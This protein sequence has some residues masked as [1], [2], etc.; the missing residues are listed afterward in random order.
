MTRPSLLVPA[1]AVA[2]LLTAAPVA[3]ASRSASIEFDLA[4][5][6]GLDAHVE[7][8]AGE[9]T[10]EIDNRHSAATYQVDGESTEA[11]LKAQLGKLGLI[12]VTFEPTKTLE[13]N[14]PPKG[15]KGEP[16]TEREGFYLGTIRFNGERE[17]VRIEAT[18]ARGTMFVS[19]N[20]QCRDGKGPIR[21]ESAPRS[22]TSRLRRQPDPAEASLLARDRRCRCFF[23][24]FAIPNRDGRV[25]S[26]FYGAKAENREGMKIGRVTFAKA[27]PS[28]FEFDHQAGVAKVEP[29]QPF[30]GTA[31]YK[32]RKGRDLW[33]SSLRVPLLGADPVSLRGREFR[34]RLTRRL[35]G[36]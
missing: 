18:R 26:L 28:A 2:L 36:D 6:N 30:T 16:W 14:K 32:R 21:L 19:P 33:S 10:L 24:A 7:A 8:F 11:G 25:L 20:W 31:T 5:N 29:P 17:Y 4:G 9:V 23:G 34:A 27:G 22:S 35:P 1:L 13:T 3:S 15:C 12:D